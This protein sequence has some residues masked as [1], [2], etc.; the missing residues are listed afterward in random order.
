MTIL[1]EAQSIVDGPRAIDYGPAEAHHGATAAMVTAYLR[2]KG[3][4]VTVDANDWQMFMVLD[5]VVR[6]AQ[7]YKRDNLVDICGYARC[8]EMCAPVGKP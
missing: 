4:D 1:E 3:Y 7:G 6:Q 5:K 2:R 8:A